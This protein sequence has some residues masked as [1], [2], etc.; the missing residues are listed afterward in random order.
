MMSS[1]N[2]GGNK[3][4]RLESKII[5]NEY[6]LTEDKDNWEDAIVEAANPDATTTD[7]I[8]STDF[9]IKQLDTGIC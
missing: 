4:H 5:A 1:W 8:F 7:E 6:I 3:A 9:A 2:T